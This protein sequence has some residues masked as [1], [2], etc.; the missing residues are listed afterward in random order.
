M[1]SPRGP[2]EIALFGNGNEIP[3][4]PEFG[5]FVHVA[6]ALDRL[7]AVVFGGPQV[8]HS[9]G[10]RTLYFRCVKNNVEATI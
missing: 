6:P 10:C 1:E 5:S 4:M 9:V 8:M 7:R 3:E 2:A